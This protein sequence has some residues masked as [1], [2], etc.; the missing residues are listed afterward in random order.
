MSCAVPAAVAALPTSG[1][2]ILTR[3]RQTIVSRWA[4]RGY[5]KKNMDAEC[6]MVKHGLFV[7]LIKSW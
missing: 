3:T 6:V 4:G 2:C 7:W 5:H 1:A